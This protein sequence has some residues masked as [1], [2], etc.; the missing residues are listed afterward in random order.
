MWQIHAAAATA[1]RF[2]GNFHFMQNHFELFK[3]PVKYAI[4]RT[5]LDDAY[6]EI[7]K[8]VHPDKFVNASDTEKRVAMQWAMHTNDAYQILR[9]PIKRAIYLCELHGFDAEMQS[10]V[11]M[12]SDFLLSQI[13]W[14]E[15]L[16]NARTDK[17]V[18]KLEKLSIELRTI[19]QKNMEQLHQMLQSQHFGEAIQLVR[20]MVFI[21]KFNDEINFAFDQIDS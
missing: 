12:S 19:Q 16:E 20:K 18:D 1:L 11:T 17:N 9:H 7:Q 14:R 2:D 4:D 5:V 3:L 6:R 10:N 8:I 15:T 13:E 21:E